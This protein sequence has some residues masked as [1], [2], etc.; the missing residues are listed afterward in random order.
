[1]KNIPGPFREKDLES[2]RRLNW[3]NP[4]DGLHE[5]E[6]LGGIANHTVACNITREQG[7][8]ATNNRLK[9]GAEVAILAG[10][11]SAKLHP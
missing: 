2:I 8:L 4:G 6:P 5:G 3:T 7:A 9:L 10:E 11:I 1:M